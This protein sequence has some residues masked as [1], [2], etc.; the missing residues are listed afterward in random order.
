MIESMA[1]GTPVLGM[2]LGSVPEV[3]AHGETGFVCHNYEEMAAIIPAAVQL[4]RQTCREHVKNH[5]TVTQMVDGYEAA[6]RQVLESRAVL[7]ER[8][9]T[10]KLVS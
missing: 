2:N 3:I 6:Y 9:H 4:D 8:I 7:S 1:T 5:F 10:L